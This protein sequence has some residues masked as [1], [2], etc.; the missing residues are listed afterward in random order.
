MALLLGGCEALGGGDTLVLDS[1]EVEIAGSV[2]EVRITGAGSSGSIAPT[3][4]EVEPGD[5]VRFV[6][7]DRRPHALAF[8]ADALA[9]EVREYLERTGQLRGP[10]LVS[11]GAA[12]VV[13]LEEAPPGR[14]PFRCLSHQATG[15]LV[16]R[17]DG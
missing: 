15:E 13:V 6:T 1:A 3:T 16:V 11:E 2:H 4:L 9:P 14:Y 8:T 12:W 5:A 7:G 17:E 10:P